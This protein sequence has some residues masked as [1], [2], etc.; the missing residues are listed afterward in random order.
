M[1]KTESQ[2]RGLEA[3][4]QEEVGKPALFLLTAREAFRKSNPPDEV[5]GRIR[6]SQAER[7]IGYRR[8]DHHVAT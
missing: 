5:D 6:Q 4:H 8:W 2:F 7:L 1:W 3:T